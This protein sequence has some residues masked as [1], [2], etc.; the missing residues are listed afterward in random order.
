MNEDL[1]TTME[2]LAV[3]SKSFELFRPIAEIKQDGK[4]LRACL[5]DLTLDKW[6]E[7]YSDFYTSSTIT[8]Q[9]LHDQSKHNKQTNNEIADLLSK[10]TKIKQ[11]YLLK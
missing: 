10:M 8:S 9:N 6:V 5:I 2:S 4:D 7:K 1:T 11:S 3:T